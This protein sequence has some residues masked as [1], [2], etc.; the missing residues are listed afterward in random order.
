MVLLS[1]KKVMMSVT[2]SAVVASAFVGADVTEAASYK[3]KRG[4]TLWSIAQKYNTTVSQLKKINNSTS[5]TIYVNQALKTKASSNSSTS[6]NSSGKS[7]SKS[8]TYTV[9]R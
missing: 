4:D 2:A 6:S 5:D 1:N 9:K 8:G 3:V 7:S